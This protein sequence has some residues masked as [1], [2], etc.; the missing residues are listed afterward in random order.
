[1]FMPAGTLFHAFP[2]GK[3]PSKYTWLTLSPFKIIN[4]LPWAILPALSSLIPSHTL[5]PQLNSSQLRYFFLQPSYT[6]S[7]VISTF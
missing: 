5:C 1:M 6:S 3:S 2:L 4:S 7:N